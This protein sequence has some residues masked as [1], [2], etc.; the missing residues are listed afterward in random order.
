V[1]E[2][3]EAVKEGG[4]REGDKRKVVK[5]RLWNQRRRSRR[6]EMTKEGGQGRRPR[7]AAKEGWPRKVGQGEV[8]K[9]MCKRGWYMKSFGNQSRW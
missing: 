9:G 1:V 7:K 6:R 5:G 3:K 2:S 4:Q 8:I